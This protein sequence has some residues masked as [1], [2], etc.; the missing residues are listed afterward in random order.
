[1][2][3]FCTYSKPYENFIKFSVFIKNFFLLKD[4]TLY[5]FCIVHFLKSQYFYEDSFFIKNRIS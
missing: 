5:N 1:M 2:Y 4:Q 3:Q